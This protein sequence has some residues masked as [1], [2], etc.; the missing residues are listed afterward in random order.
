[1]NQAFQC[2]NVRELS[3]VYRVE[4]VKKSKVIRSMSSFTDFICND[5]V[6]S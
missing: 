1:M 6:K 4:A 3:T 5:K 2:Y